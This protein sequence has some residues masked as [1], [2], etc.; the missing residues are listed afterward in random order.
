MY[1]L[2]ITTIVQYQPGLAW[3]GGHKATRYRFTYL[4]SNRSWIL[5]WLI[6]S[7][8]REEG[9][10]FVKKSV[11]S[12]HATYC[13]LASWH[14]LKYQGME[15]DIINFFPIKFYVHSAQLRHSI[16]AGFVFS[17]FHLNL[18]PV[19]KIQYIHVQFRALVII[20]AHWVGKRNIYIGL[21][22][23]S[24]LDVMVRSYLP[25]S[26]TK[27]FISIMTLQY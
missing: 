23:A 27:I 2:F 24:H 17:T 21:H 1:R 7:M 12:F 19:D 10:S 4:S 18:C 20:S 16:M 11:E 15:M 13:I 9:V 25:V 5:I 6:I 26:L 3:F 22:V 8:D 14:Q